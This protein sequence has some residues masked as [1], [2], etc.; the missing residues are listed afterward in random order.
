MLNSYEAVL[1]HGTVR[2]LGTPPAVERAPLIITVLPGKVTEDQHD[3]QFRR[4]PDKIKG[5]LHIAGD[6][7]ESPYSEEEW[8]SMSERTLRQLEGDPKAFK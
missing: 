2:W 5:R 1:D 6:I 4:P 7:V 3:S 8:S